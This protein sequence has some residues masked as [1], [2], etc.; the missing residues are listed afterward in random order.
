MARNALVRAILHAEADDLV[1]RNV[2]ALVTTPVG[3]EGRPSKSLT[4]SQAQALIKAAV[5]SR[6]YA[7]CAG[8]T[9][10]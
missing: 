7:Y 6:L 4:L 3:L 10:T 1:G 2:A 8:I 9:W 5:A